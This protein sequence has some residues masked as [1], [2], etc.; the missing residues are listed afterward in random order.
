MIL[1][2]GITGVVLTMY[3]CVGSLKLDIIVKSL[4]CDWQTDLEPDRPTTWEA[5][6]SKNTS[7]H[8]YYMKTGLGK[9]WNSLTDMPCLN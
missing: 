7:E 2:F 4:K 3:L 5:I 9:T 8:F 1:I 6:A